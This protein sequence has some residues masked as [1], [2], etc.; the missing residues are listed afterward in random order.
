[1]RSANPLAAVRVRFDNGLLKIGGHVGGYVRGADL[2]PGR[3]SRF[4]MPTRPVCPSTVACR[5]AA[6]SFRNAAGVKTRAARGVHRPRGACRRRRSEVGCLCWGNPL[7]SHVETTKVGSCS[8]IL[9]HRA[10]AAKLHTAGARVPAA[11]GNGCS[12]TWEALVKDQGYDCQVDPGVSEGLAGLDPPFAIPAGAAG[13]P[14]RRVPP[15][16]ASSHIT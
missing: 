5:A 11:S 10:A 9:P 16:P 12:V 13:L 4:A 3:C 15:A 8:R 14:R 1:M 2:P 6:A 7:R